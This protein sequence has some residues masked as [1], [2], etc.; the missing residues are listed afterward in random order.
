MIMM[1]C[2]EVGLMCSEVVDISFDIYEGLL[3]RIK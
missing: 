2:S 1:D 3:K